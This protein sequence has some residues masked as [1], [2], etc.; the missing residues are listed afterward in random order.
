[1]EAGCLARNNIGS[2]GGGQRIHGGKCKEVWL[3]R[4]LDDG[5]GEER[6][7]RVWLVRSVPLSIAG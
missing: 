5:I 3:S 6:W 4:H 2:E 7:L 1:M